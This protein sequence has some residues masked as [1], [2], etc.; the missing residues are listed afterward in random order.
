MVKIL[1]IPAG[2]KQVRSVNPVK[3]PTKVTENSLHPMLKES[4]GNYTFS[5][6]L[7]KFRNQLLQG[8]MALASDGSLSVATSGTHGWIVLHS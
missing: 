6:N 3:L 2:I 8:K 1:G 4:I 5:P 7:I